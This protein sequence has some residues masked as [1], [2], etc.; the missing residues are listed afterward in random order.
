MNDVVNEILTSVALLALAAGSVTHTVWLRRLDGRVRK[1]EEFALKR[2]IT[3]YITA[4]RNA[5]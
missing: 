4:K 2:S 1:L 3:D 5:E